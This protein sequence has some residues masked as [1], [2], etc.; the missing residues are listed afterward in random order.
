MPLDI[1]SRNE[2]ICKL[3]SDLKWSHIV[4]AGMLGGIGFTMSIFIANLAFS[5]NAA[6][7]NTAKMAILVA[8]SLAGILGYLC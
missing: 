5:N 1:T 2:T 8:S 3:P 6:E 7:I 4:G